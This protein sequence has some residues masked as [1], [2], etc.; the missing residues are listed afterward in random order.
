MRLSPRYDAP[1]IMSIG[2]QPDDQRD[3][4]TRQ[5]RRLEAT[6][7][8]LSED[9]WASESRCDGWAVQDVVAHIV[10]VNAFWHGSVMAGLAGTPTRVLAGF[11]PATTPPLM[12]EPM[13]ALK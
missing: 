6:L 3:P 12:V 2:G 1:P 13:R 9:A 4:L 8:G 5:R 10:G 7:A 11:D